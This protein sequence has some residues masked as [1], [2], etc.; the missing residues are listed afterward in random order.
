MDDEKTVE[1]SDDQ[2][3]HY[4]AVLCSLWDSYIKYLHVGMAAAGFTII[5]VAEYLKGGGSLQAGMGMYAKIAIT[6]AGGAG[7]CFALCRWICQL[8]ME[9][10]VY[11]SEKLAAA[12]FRLCNTRSANALL[13]TSQQIA[14]FYWLNDKLKYT[15]S[16]L[17]LLSW[18]LIIIILWGW[19]NQLTFVSG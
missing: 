2:I 8:I 7:L 10:Q 12:Y 16:I 17:L 11:G 5:Y 6:S 1:L 9:R 19:V 15:G 3:K 18:V 14:R 13:Y 4:S